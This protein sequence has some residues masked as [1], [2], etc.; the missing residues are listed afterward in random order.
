M[1]TIL[2]RWTE[3]V[4]CDNF[5]K[6]VDSSSLVHHRFSTN[7]RDQLEAILKLP[8]LLNLQYSGYKNKERDFVIQHKLRQNAFFAKMF[9]NL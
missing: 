2:D 9:F 4:L 7:L 8:Q 6:K 5:G 3:A 1:A